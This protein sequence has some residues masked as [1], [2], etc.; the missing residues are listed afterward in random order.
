MGVCRYVDVAD[1][2]VGVDERGEDDRDLIF[3]REV[4]VEVEME[5]EGI[6]LEGG[7]GN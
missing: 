2:G 1:T 6:D 5:T 7:S 4:E 3:G